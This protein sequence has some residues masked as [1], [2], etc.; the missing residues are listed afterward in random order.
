MENVVKQKQFLEIEKSDD[1]I[2]LIF[3]RP[4][5]AMAALQTSTSLTR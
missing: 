4:G 5:V 3:D 1:S 2:F